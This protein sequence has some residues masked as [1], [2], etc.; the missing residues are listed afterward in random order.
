M[1]Y[2]VDPSENTDGKYYVAYLYSDTEP[3][4]RY[5]CYVQTYTTKAVG[6]DGARS[7]IVYFVTY[8][9]GKLLN[10]IIRTQYVTL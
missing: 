2:E 6:V 4:R 1:V 7:E 5:A 10:P 8:P 9:S 3:Y